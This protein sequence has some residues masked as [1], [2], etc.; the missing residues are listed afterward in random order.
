MENWLYSNNG[1]NYVTTGAERRYQKKEANHGVCE[2]PFSNVVS[3]TE[4]S[5]EAQTAYFQKYV[6]ETHR[7]VSLLVP[8]FFLLHRIN[9]HVKY[10]LI[11]QADIA[12]LL[13]ML[14]CHTT[15]L[16]NKLDV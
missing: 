8:A 11:N 13:L 15:L 9:V 6:T 14:R 5:D 3:Q 7:T 4:W 12:L 10:L 16:L 2:G 1:C